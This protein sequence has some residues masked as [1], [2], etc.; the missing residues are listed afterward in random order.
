MRFWMSG[1]QT[2]IFI[3]L[4]WISAILVCFSYADQ[5]VV[6]HRA[7]LRKD[8]STAQRPIAVLAV[9]DEVELVDN[10]QTNG[11]FHVRTDDGDEGFVFARYLRVE[12]PAASAPSSTSHGALGGPL[13]DTVSQDWEKP[14]PNSTTFDGAD[15]TCGPGGDGGDQLTNP[16]KNR[17]DVPSTYHDVTWNA[18]AGLTYPD[19]KARSLEGWT[20]DQRDQIM[21]FEGIPV[22]TIGYIVAIKVESRG[23]GESTNCHFTGTDEVDWH[24]PLVQAAGDGEKT[25]IV[26]ETTPRVR[27]SHPKWT[28]EALAPWVN[29]DAPVRV[30]GYLLFDPEHRAHLGVYRSTLWEI[31]PITKI[32]V[33]QSNAWVDLDRLP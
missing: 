27:E 32:E 30:S 25:S 10:T 17:T 14:A 28:P 11:Y 4:S 9:D 15:G 12:T 19:A 13:A 29:S 5:A 6:T 7:T 3:R 22:R 21:L 18:I 20:S 31:H 2:R 16:R 1:G 8:P 23:S 24:V 33:F 26:V